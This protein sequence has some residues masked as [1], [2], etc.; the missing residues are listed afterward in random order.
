[1]K[2]LFLVEIFLVCQEKLEE[3]K[4]ALVKLTDIYYCKVNITTLLRLDVVLVSFRIAG[5]LTVFF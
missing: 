3:N 1:M 2:G 5:N 4:C